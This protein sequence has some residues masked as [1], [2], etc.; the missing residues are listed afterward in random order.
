M[1]NKGILLSEI[2]NIPEENQTVD[3]GYK[4]DFISNL[5]FKET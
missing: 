3:S 1:E 2:K 5:F 4:G